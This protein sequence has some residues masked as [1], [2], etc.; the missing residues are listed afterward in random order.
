MSKGLEYLIIT[1]VPLRKCLNLVLI[2]IVEELSARPDVEILTVTTENWDQ[3]PGII[4]A[5]MTGQL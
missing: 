5:K 2:F 1:L 4:V 3:L